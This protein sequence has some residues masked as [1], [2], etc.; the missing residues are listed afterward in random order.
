[1]LSPETPRN[2]KRIYMLV[3]SRAV[4]ADDM[5]DGTPHYSIDNNEILFN[6]PNDFRN[7]CGVLST[8]FHEVGHMIDYNACNGAI[9]SNDEL[10]SKALTE[11][12]SHYIKTVMETH[13]CSKDTAYDF[14]RRELMS[15][16]NL[17][18]DVSDIMG[19]LTN[20]HCQNLWGHSR[21]Y[22]M[23]DA[24]RIQREAFANMFSTSMQGEKKIEAMK[25]F[26]P[27]AYKRFEVIIEGVKYDRNR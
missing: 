22:W 23:E 3:G 5:F 1:L 11:D 8:Y 26:F 16:N 17:Y 21:S 18:S 10:F 7:P 14:I 15:D 27:N 4:I 2:A 9:L 13:G 25:Q 24:K 20:G 6:L 19:S 12:C